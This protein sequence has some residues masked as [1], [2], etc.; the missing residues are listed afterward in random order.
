MKMTDTLQFA[1][2]F[3][4][5]ATYFDEITPTSEFTVEAELN[6]HPY[7]DPNRYT[8]EQFKEECPDPDKKISANSPQCG[9]SVDNL[10]ALFGRFIEE[11]N[12]WVFQ[13]DEDAVRKII[14]SSFDFQKVSAAYLLLQDGYISPENYKIDKFT[15][16][17]SQLLDANMM[18]EAELLSVFIE[19]RGLIKRLL[20]PASEGFWDLYSSTP[21]GLAEYRESLLSSPA[22]QPAP[23]ITELSPEVSKCDELPEG[24]RFSALEWATIFYYADESKLTSSGRTKKARIDDF[25]KQ[26]NIQTTLGNMRTKYHA[27]KRDISANTYSIP[28]LSSIIP[29][30]KANYPQVVTKIENDI[31]FIKEETPEY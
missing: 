15:P 31:E 7:T 2:A 28:K 5:I 11:L 12:V 23:Q 26:H 8:L 20:T 18:K 19:C 30:L 9:V 16:E 24:T 21:S 29:F 6:L 25:M 14:D 10:K 13:S 3:N 17:V 1:K 22:M 4:D 27:A